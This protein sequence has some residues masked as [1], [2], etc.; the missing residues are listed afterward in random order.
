VLVLDR[1]LVAEF[2]TPAALLSRPD[3]VFTSMVDDTGEATA[4]FL[5]GVAAGQVGSRA[6]VMCQ[7]LPQ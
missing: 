5:R 1:G 3:G 2:G 4:K 6:I 7:I